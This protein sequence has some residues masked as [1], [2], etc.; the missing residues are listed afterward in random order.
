MLWESKSFS[1]GFVLEIVPVSLSEQETRKVNLLRALTHV[2]NKKDL[3]LLR[4]SVVTNF[5]EI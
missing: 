1:S 2:F 5:A 3:L 4:Q